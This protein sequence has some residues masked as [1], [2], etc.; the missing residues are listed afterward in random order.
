MH[1]VFQDL[2]HRGIKTQLLALRMSSIPLSCC[3]S[4]SY[5]LPENSRQCRV[6]ASLFWKLGTGC[7]HASLCKQGLQLEALLKE[8]NHPFTDLKLQVEEPEKAELP[9]L[10]EEFTNGAL[11]YEVTSA[12]VEL[13]LS[14]SRQQGAR[15]YFLI[16]V[17]VCHFT[18][19][20]II[21]LHGVQG[22]SLGPGKR[23]V[24]IPFVRTTYFQLKLLFI[25][26]VCVSLPL[27]GRQHA[28]YTPQNHSFPTTEALCCARWDL[29]VI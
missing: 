4:D 26:T 20:R 10:H 27:T 16:S 19:K 12:R 18:A 6:L 21:L 14:L 11:V 5:L 25:S 2:S 3:V 9:L 1:L 28:D 7:P 8:D 13:N 24:L 17:G 29:R 15:K 23:R 22:D